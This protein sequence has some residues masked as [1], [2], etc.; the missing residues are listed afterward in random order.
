MPCG[1]GP[2]WGVRPAPLTDTS[3]P[4]ERAASGADPCSNRSAGVTQ[5]NPSEQRTFSALGSAGGA[6]LWGHK[7]KVIWRISS[8]S[9]IC[10]R[11]CFPR[12]AHA[13]WA[14]E[15]PL[16]TVANRSVRW[17][18]DQTWTRHARSRGQRRSAS[19]TLAGKETP[20]GC[21]RQAS[22]AWQSPCLGG[23]LAGSG[24][25]T[26]PYVG[27]VPGHRHGY[28]S[29]LRV[30]TTRTITGLVPSGR[31]RLRRSGPPRPGPDRPTGHGKADQAWRRDH[32][33]L[34]SVGSRAASTQRS[35]GCRRFSLLEVSQS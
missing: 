31:G 34:Q 7:W 22:P 23:A 33:L 17:R 8:L 11:A 15:V 6:G 9:G 27:A 3:L 26:S 16:E 13:T 10:A 35:Q 1:T 20:T 32:L 18:V 14:N 28:P 30:E 25:E 19:R 2:P 5:R 24:P 29:A 21:P 12:I 4:T